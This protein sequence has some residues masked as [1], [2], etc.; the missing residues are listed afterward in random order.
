MTYLAN[1]FAKYSV[2]RWN[3]SRLLRALCRFVYRV[4]GAV[5]IFFS[6]DKY[7]LG[8]CSRSEFEPDFTTIR[9]DTYPWPYRELDF[10]RWDED[11]A[12]GSYT[13]VSDPAGFVIRHSTSYCAWKIREL[14]GH[15]PKRRQP[16]V[17]YHAKN[18]QAFLAENGYTTVIDSPANAIFQNC[19]GID[20]DHGEFGQLYWYERPRFARTD[21]SSVQCTG[22]YCSTYEAGTFLRFYQSICLDLEAA[23]KLTWI[24]IR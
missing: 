22:F 24:V 5:Y 11:N 9:D 19:V 12:I 20:P 15:W 14:T 4:M 17:I 7:F 21:G 3:H 13:L 16:G 18:W 23:K 6:H 1:F 10:A 2:D 8:G